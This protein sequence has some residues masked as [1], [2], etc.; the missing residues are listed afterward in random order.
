MKKTTWVFFFHKHSKFWSISL[1]DL[2]DQKPFISQEC[3][4]ESV[5]NMKCLF[6]LWASF[7][8]IIHAYIFLKNLLEKVFG[9]AYYQQRWY[10]T[11]SFLIKINYCCK[12]SLSNILAWS[13]SFLTPYKT[14]GTLHFVRYFWNLLSKNLTKHEII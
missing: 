10:S 13:A 11:N 4:K 7:V 9:K 1:E 2:V 6:V 3:N 12:W 14:W 8:S 5:S